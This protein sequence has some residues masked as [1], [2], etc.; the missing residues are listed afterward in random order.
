MHSI[1][2]LRAHRGVFSS[3][4]TAAKKSRR[5]RSARLAS[6]T[7]ATRR[8]MMRLTPQA[9][10]PAAAR[11]AVTTA[12][13]MLQNAEGSSPAAGRLATMVR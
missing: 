10:S 1:W 7:S 2:A 11:M 4:D 12:G 6:A 13:S 3:W 8:V 5:C 9:T